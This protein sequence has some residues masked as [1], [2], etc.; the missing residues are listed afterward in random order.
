MP[1]AKK[2]APIRCAVVGYGGAFNMGKHHLEQI[3]A[4]PGL[5]G[6]A[7]CDVDKARTA[8]AKADFPEMEV[9][10]DL[11]KMIQWGEFDLAVIITPHNTHARLAIQ[12][13]EAGK[14]VIVE[15]P[16]CI[17]IK[18]ATAMIEAAKKA[19]KMLS[20]Y[21]NR[22]WDGDFLTIMEVIE[23]GLIGDVFRVEATSASYGDP[24]TWWRSDKKISGGAMYDWGAHFIYWILRIIP[25]KMVNVTGF[26]QKRVW[27]HVTNEDEVEAIIR[28][29]SGAVASYQQSSIAR[30]GRPKWR[31]LGT[32]G[33]ITGG[34]ESIE[35]HTDVKGIPAVA[36]LKP[37]DSP[38]GAYY[39]NIA[40]H[41]LRG[42]PL[43]ITAESARR[44]IAVIDCAE[45]SWKTGKAVPVPYE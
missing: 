29:E 5:T 33:A 2:A 31:I 43:E 25:E 20:V 38:W 41:L 40:D 15:K 3:N 36:T 6:V 18:E 45:Q 39:S 42:K 14:H 12:C 17:T 10:N 22:R 30:V 16:M 8:Q 24:G 11:G 4:I 37:K 23:K 21:H 9:F 32:K 27:D 35:V 1:P 13:S 28:F 26:M 7:V 34:W 44:V 19:G